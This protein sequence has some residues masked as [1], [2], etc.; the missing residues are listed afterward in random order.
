VGHVHHDLLSR[1]TGEIADEYARLHSAAL[2][3]P[4]RA[5]HGGEMTWA[6]FLE[7]W[8]PPGYAVGT[9]KY[10]VPEQGDEAF[11]TDLVVFNRAYPERLHGREEVLVVAWRPLSASS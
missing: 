4:Q 5:G 2:D 8:L 10:I 7:D 11:E 6:R 9:R 3:D 1:L